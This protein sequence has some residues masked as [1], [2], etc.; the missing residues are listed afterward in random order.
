MRPAAVETVVDRG[1][2]GCRI[3]LQPWQMNLYLL[4]VELGLAQHYYTAWLAALRAFEI[5]V[6]AAAA[7]ETF[8]I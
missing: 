7:V 6:A 1:A 8:V 4:H 5:V 3:H 2:F